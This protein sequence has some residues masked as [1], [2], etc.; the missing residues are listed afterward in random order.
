MGSYPG[1]MGSSMMLPLI[2]MSAAIESFKLLAGLLGEAL[3]PVGV[4][5][6]DQRVPAGA[7][8]VA[9]ID[10][11]ACGEA[12]AVTGEF[13]DGVCRHRCSTARHC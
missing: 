3:D 1:R 5:G 11:I 10:L 9:R 7:D 4:V 2:V 8:D 12:N 6:V 13:G